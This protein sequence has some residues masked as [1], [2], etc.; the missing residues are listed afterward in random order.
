MTH[1]HAR[2]DRHGY[3]RRHRHRQGRNALALLR[4]GYRVV[5]AGRR[6]ELLEQVIV[7]AGAASRRAPLPWPPT[8]A[9]RLR[10]ARCSRRPRRRFGRLDLLFNNAGVGA[11]GINLEELSY[12]QWKTVVDTNLTRRVSLPAGGVPADEEPRPARR[13]HHQQRL[14]FGAR[15]A[16]ELRALHRDQARDHRAHQVGFARRAQV[17]HRLRADRHR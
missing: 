6:K 5:L 11:P 8:S 10:C 14:D 15:P 1:G 13:A 4:D 7:E 3:R 2:Q 16:A 12:E 17:R 9:I